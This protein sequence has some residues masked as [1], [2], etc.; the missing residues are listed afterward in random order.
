MALNESLSQAGKCC[1]TH[2]VWT[3]VNAADAPP[4]CTCIDLGNVGCRLVSAAAEVNV[5]FGR[6]RCI[7]R[8][9]VIVT[10]HINAR[11]NSVTS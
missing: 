10:W 3:G 8:L 7:N 4:F 11:E 5:W 6:R 9:N 1:F 2:L